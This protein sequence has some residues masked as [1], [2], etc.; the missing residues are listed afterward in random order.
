MLRYRSD[1]WN[2]FL[3]VSRVKKCH[4]SS[5]E[6]GG[7]TQS[8]EDEHKEEGGNCQSHG[9]S[10]QSLEL[11]SLK[12]LSNVFNDNIGIHNDENQVGGKM[13]TGSN[14]SKVDESDE[15]C[16]DGAKGVE[17]AVCYVDLHI[18]LVDEHY[19]HFLFL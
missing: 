11:L 5:T 10:C 15:H 14:D 3:G 6:S 19:P 4:G 13:L 8:Q 7:A 9:Q 2:V 18:E 16:H 17:H 12:V 1:N